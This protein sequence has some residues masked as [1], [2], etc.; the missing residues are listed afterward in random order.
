MYDMYVWRAGGEGG[1][2]RGQLSCLPEEGSLGYAERLAL[3]SLCYVKGAQTDCRAQMVWQ[4][5]LCK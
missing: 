1:G 3:A 2:V 5:V 4:A